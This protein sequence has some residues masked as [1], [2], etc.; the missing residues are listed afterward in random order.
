MTSI[1]LSIGNVN[2]L[3]VIININTTLSKNYNN[4]EGDESKWLTILTVDEKDAIIYYTGQNYM[5]INYYL[6]SN[7]R[8]LPPRTTISKLELD[9]KIRL[10]DCAIS[11]AVLKENIMVYRNVGEQE[12][13]EAKY[14]LQPIWGPD[15]N[16]L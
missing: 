3:A 6:R 5:Y 8:D 11:K 9:N 15:L 14:L 12:F 2:A 7:K 16:S 10:I 1:V 13:K 4:L